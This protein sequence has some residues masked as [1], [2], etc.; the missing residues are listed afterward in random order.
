M[1]VIKALSET[2]QKAIQNC[3]FALQ[4]LQAIQS[5]HANKCMFVLPNLIVMLN[6]FQDELVSG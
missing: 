1:W 2:Q 5:L 6:L 4:S 3:T